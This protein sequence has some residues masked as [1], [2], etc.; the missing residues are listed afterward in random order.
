MKK[1][2]I[3]AFCIM[4]NLSL[5][6]A[7]DKLRPEVNKDEYTLASGYRGFVDFGYTAGTGTY[8]LGRVSLLTSHG[9]QFNP[10]IFM[11]AGLGIN[12]YHE[13]ASANVPVFTHLKG[14]FMKGRIVPF[15]ELKIGYALAEVTG[16]YMNP[17]VGCRMGINKRIGFN[18][19]LGY[20]V[21]QTE[22]YFYNDQTSFYSDK[23]LGGFSFKV[24]IDF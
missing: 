16:F 11:G 10:Y 19:C 5:S 15:A 6:F 21:Q 13:T 9:Y 12:Y 20:E 4:G 23:N 7:N 24:G 1:V 18:F 22:L 8:S 3:A 17:S 2:F 14:T